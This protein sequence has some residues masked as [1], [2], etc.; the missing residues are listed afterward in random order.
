MLQ[1]DYIL[2][3][4]KEFLEALE[5]VVRDK[6]DY[7]ETEKRL[8]E[9]Y[10]TYLDAPEFY[11]T[12]TMDDVMDS[13]TRYPEDERLDRI[14]MLANLYYVDGG[15]KTGVSREFF[16]KRALRLFVFIDSHSRT[17]SFDRVSKIDAIKKELSD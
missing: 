16:M 4:I 1:R 9:L 3:I 6:K 2:R 7:A 10:R 8:T 11:R 14:E 13:F 15:M 17:Y 5:L 12:A